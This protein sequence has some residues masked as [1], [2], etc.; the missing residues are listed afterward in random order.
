MCFP[1]ADEGRKNERKREMKAI[2]G[3]RMREEGG[4]SSTIKADKGERMRERQRSEG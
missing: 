1:A 4:R 3:E 2:K